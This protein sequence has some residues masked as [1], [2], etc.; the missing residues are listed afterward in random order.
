VSRQTTQQERNAIADE[1]TFGRGPSPSINALIDEVL[2]LRAQLT[3][4]EQDRDAAQVALHMMQWPARA[5]AVQ[6]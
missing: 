4:C 1:F 3:E 2:A 5:R 6:P